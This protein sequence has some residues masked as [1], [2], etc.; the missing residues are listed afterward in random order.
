M[1]ARMPRLRRGQIRRRQ[2][3]ERQILSTTNSFK[4]NLEKLANLPT[5]L[6][7]APLPGTFSAAIDIA[8]IDIKNLNLQ[9][10]ATG[11]TRLRSPSG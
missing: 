9:A 2:I 6:R 1:A 8:A 3:R 5:R 7:I 11:A 4:Q 10:S